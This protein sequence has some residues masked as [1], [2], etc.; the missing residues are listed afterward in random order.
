M[1][2]VHKISKTRRS[3]DVGRGIDTILKTLQEFVF[4]CGFVVVVVFSFLEEVGCWER[5]RY[6]PEDIAGARVWGGW[7]DKIVK[8]RVR[9][10]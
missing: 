1:A 7:V 5:G 4:V 9:E 2:G 8:T 6:N 10:H 3:S